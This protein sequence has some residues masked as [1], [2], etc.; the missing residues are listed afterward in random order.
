MNIDILRKNTPKDN[1]INEII[2]IEW[3]MFQHVSGLT[4]RAPCQDD[5]KTFYIMRYSQHSAFQVTT[6]FSYKN[7]LMNAKENSR[8]LIAEK[9]AYMM[10]YS[11]PELYKKDIEDKVPEISAIKMELIYKIMSMMDADKKIVQARYPNID[12]YSRPET[13]GEAGTSS[14]AYNIGELKTYSFK[15]LKKME[16]DILEAHSRGENIVETIYTNTMEFY[17]FAD[18]DRAEQVYSK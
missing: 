11:D 7:D 6:L 15:T 14:K 2:D 5:M 1:M 3:E 18:L 16:E 17:G 9:Y 4:G 12:K 8:N 10:E 13:D